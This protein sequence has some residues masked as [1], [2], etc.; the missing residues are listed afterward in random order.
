LYFSS[1]ARPKKILFDHLP[2]CGG[3]SLNA[4][5]QAHYPRRKTFSTNGSDSIASADKFKHLSE[6]KRYG[7]DFIKGHMAHELLDWAHPECLKV[8]LFR[9]PV[10]RIISHYHYA[11]ATPIH[12]LHSKIHTLGLTLDDYVSLDGL[13]AELR[14]WYTTHFS[15]LTIAEAEQNPEESISRA[16]DTVLNRYDLVGFLDNFSS[17]TEK[18]REQA[19]LR[20]PYENGKLNVTADK[21][22][23]NRIAPSTLSKIEQVNFLD[24]A[25]YN[26]L[27]DALA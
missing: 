16:V 27:R 20:Y 8:T 14:N 5:L 6:D 1:A 24:V 15:G 12:Y 9:D 22:P 4:Y 3:S 2:K 25:F 21:P 23:R 11:K 7:Y 19:N 10:E 26:R 13:S 18:L 17:F